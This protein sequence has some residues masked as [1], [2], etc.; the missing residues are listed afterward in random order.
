MNNP[1]AKESRCVSLA[2]SVISSTARC[3]GAMREVSINCG[4][5]GSAVVFIELFPM[6]AHFGQKRAGSE[7]RSGLL[8][9][10]GKLMDDRR[11]TQTVGIPERPA[12]EWSPACAHDH[13]EIDILCTI[14][15]AFFEA[16]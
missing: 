14:D 16:A 4:P 6:A 5:S 7:L 13:C 1:P 8:R 2:A 3:S 15:H 11:G 12:A 10:A 9:Q